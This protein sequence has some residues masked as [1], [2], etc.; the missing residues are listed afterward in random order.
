MNANQLNL[1][2]TRLQDVISPILNILHMDV[3]KPRTVNLP[4][5]T[6]HAFMSIIC[7]LVELIPAIHR[8]PFHLKI[9]QL[10]KEFL[11]WSA[12]INAKLLLED[13]KELKPFQEFKASF[14]TIT[15]ISLLAGENSFTS[16]FGI[17]DLEY[18]AANLPEVA[19][20][21]RQQMQ[22]VDLIVQTPLQRLFEQ[23]AAAMQENAQNKGY[24]MTR[25]DCIVSQG[26]VKPQIYWVE[27]ETARQIRDGVVV[28]HVRPS[29]SDSS[30]SPKRQ[31]L[32]DSQVSDD[33]F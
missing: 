8:S 25:G 29:L 3:W 26:I 6:L 18:Y 5:Q 14:V 22:D 4:V 15:N 1:I 27:K 13:L 10:A 31:R 23:I 12:L 28:A 9:D 7:G 30:Q 24:T 17:S 33:M 32:A 2:N 20:V 19:T 21:I 16:R 11:E